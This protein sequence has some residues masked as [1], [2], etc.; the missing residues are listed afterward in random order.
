MKNFIL[1]VSLLF[2]TTLY[3]QEKE[4]PKTTIY[5]NLFS[6][7]LSL[8]TKLSNNWSLLNELEISN[9]HDF[10]R[11]ELPISLKYSITKKWSVFAGPKLRYSFVKDDF[12]L[13]S[14]ENFNVLAQVGTRYDFTEDF[15]GEMIYEYNLIHKNYNEALQVSGGRLR[16][17]V[18]LKF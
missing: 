9:A 4:K 18:G 6:S 2:L 10:N 5:S 8:H 3:T 15:F 16:F 13:G 11:I 7:K 1:F 14:Y 12:Y 17:G